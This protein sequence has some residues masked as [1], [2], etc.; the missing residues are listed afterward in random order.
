MIEEV[1]PE[2][3]MN[4]K[5]IMIKGQAMIEEKEKIEEREIN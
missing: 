3:K 4:S 2:D 1:M 5:Q